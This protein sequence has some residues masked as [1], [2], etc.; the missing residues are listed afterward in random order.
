LYN[1]NKKGAKN[2]T[3]KIFG[4]FAYLLLFLFVLYAILLEITP[5][6]SGSGLVNFIF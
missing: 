6:E 4:A 5:R 1:K 2:P 3:L